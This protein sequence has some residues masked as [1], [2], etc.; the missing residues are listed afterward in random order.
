MKRMTFPSLSIGNITVPVP[1]IQGGMGVGISLS[2]LS[3]AV[4]NAGGI[5][6]ISAIGLGYLYPQQ[7]LSADESGL[8]AVKNEIRKAREL[9]NGILGINIMHALTDFDRILQTALRE[10]IDLIFIGAGLPIRL[11]KKLAFNLLDQFKS[12]IVPIVSSS[13]ALNIIFKSWDR[14]YN[15]V[16]DAVVVEGPL[17]G[18]HLGFKAN[19]IRNPLNTLEKL[20][21]Q[22]KTAIRPFAEKYKQKIPLIAAGGI[23][24]GKDIFKFIQLG[25]DGVQMG[26]RFVATNECDASIEFKEEYVNCRKED[27]GIVESP[28][29]L[30]GRGI[31]NK[32]LKDVRNG[33]R[34]P[35]RCP[36]KC[37]KNCE[38]Q[39][40]PYCIALALIN[41][42]KGRFSR[43]FAFCGE[44]AWRIR[45]IIPVQKLIDELKEG[46]CRAATEDST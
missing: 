26:T 36:Y 28:V 17:A 9:T 32:F 19:E 40:A 1:I 46:Y 44:S 13:R 20:I 31:I 34:K 41:A 35:F 7:G 27:I 24:S 23:Y 21:P 37:L 25:A 45:E 38:Y 8:A 16:P 2:G 10:E 18:G 39:S 3:S 30:P 11:P 4:A 6:V 15:R 14:K 33:S 43:G 5:G 12:K 29:G 22:V 42:L